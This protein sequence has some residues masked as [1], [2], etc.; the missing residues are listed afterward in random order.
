MART[1]RPVLTVLRSGVALDYTAID[2]GN[3]ETMSND[4]RTLI[5]FTNDSGA[6]ITVTWAWDVS[7]A[8]QDL[9]TVPEE[10]VDIDDGDDAAIGPF[11]IHLFSGTLLLDYS[12]EGSGSSWDSG[13]EAVAV[14][15]G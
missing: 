2:S 9:V 7:K 15:L 5:H 6:T 1:T 8:T 4:G 10:S 11:P 13:V 14:S 3:G 12:T